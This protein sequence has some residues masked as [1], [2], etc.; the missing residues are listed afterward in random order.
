MKTMLGI[1]LGLLVV[2]LTAA[3]SSGGAAE[4]GLSGMIRIEGGTLPEL[5]GQGWEHRI[6]DLEVGDF[7]LGRHPVTWKTWRAVRDW[8]VENGYDLDD[9]GKGCG[10]DH[11]VHSITWHDAVKW[12]NA[13][14]QKEGRTPVYRVDGGIYKTGQAAPEY[15]RQ[16]DGYRLPTEAEWEF[17]ARGGNHSRGYAYSGSDALDEVGRYWDNSGGADCAKFMG[18]GT[19]PVGRHKPNELGMYDMSGSVWEWCWDMPW[20]DARRAYRGGSWYSITG[21]H[22]YCRVDYRYGILPTYTDYGIGLR[23]AKSAPGPEGTR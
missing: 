23:V 16:A 1:A 4:D 21:G 12:C 17:A 2:A 9:R 3:N 15:D 5:P 6:G 22:D 14:S 7:H 8:A 10:D 11:P 13:R 18:R 20:D 19:W